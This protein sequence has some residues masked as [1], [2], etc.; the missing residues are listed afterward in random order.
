MNMMPI[1]SLLL[2]FGSSIVVDPIFPPN[3]VSGGTIVAELHFT[4]GKVDKM[5]ILAGEEPFV[6]SS[7]SALE[8]WQLHPEKNGS[9]IVVIYFRQPNL[10]YFAN[11][12]A[13]ISCAKPK[14]ALPYPLHI[15]GPAYPPQSLGQGG[16]VLK[17]GISAKGRVSAVQVMKS[18]GAL[19]DVSTDAVRKWVF[20]PAR[21][22][23]GIAEPSSV[24][25]VL[26]YRFLI[27]EPKN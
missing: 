5:S 16:V 26:V 1:I 17:A 8:Q 21:D 24:Y 23:Q 6:S 12:E 27:T 18:Q 20:A 13:D 14:A 7:R 9:E 2:F 10:Y 15:V 4:A 22:E 25:A 3:T 19:T 11:D